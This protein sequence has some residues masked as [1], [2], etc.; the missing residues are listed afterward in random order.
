MWT[1]LRAEPTQAVM[2][3]LEDGGHAVHAVGGCVRDALMER[4]VHDVDLSTDAH[5]P[6]VIELAQAAGLRAVPTGID[7]GTVTIVAE[8]VPHE[9]TTWR[10]DVETDGRRAVV[11]FADRLEEDALRRDF[12]MNA[13]Y[14][15]RRGAVTDPVEGLADLHARR[16]RFI[17]DA[18]ARIR[19]DYLRIL[20]FFR[21]NAWFGAE[22]DADGLAACA[23]L[24]DGLDT[25]S[26]ERVGSEMLRLLAAP[27]PAPTVATM[28]LSGILARTIPGAEAAALPVLVHLEGDLPPDPLRRLAALGGD[29]SGLRL[30]RADLRAL[31]AMRDDAAPFALGHAHGAAHARDALLVRAAALAMPPEGLD[32]ARRGAEAAFPLRAA[33]LPDLRG[34]ALGAALRRAERAWL[35]AEG[36]LD[37]AAL[38]R[39]ARAEGDPAG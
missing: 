4:P 5:P 7:H 21:F 8:G 6:R 24:A 25:L 18:H 31:E 12:T 38:I 11:A 33:D 30:S 2:A 32:A 13:L 16:V 39:A 28:A 36:A 19:E 34:P 10:R 15:D 29:P 3:L 20:R 9:V 26:R 37:R 1:W 23:E 27:D 17:G 22:I 14:A 35:A